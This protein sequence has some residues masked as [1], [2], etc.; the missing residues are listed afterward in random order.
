MK[1]RFTRP[2][3]RNLQSI[4]SHIGKDSPGAASRVVSHLIEVSRS[5]GE[6]PQQGRE[7]DEPGTRVLIVSKFRFLVFYTIADDEVRITHIRHTA[8]S[9][10]PS[11]GR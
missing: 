3:Q 1:V 5:L 8:R 9:R 4:Y 10:P 6:H 7:T 2:A 11:L